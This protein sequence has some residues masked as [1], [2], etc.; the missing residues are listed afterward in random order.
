MSSPVIQQTNEVAGIFAEAAKALNDR[1]RTVIAEHAHKGLLKSGATVRRFG[2]AFEAEARA[3]AA[4]AAILGEGQRSPIMRTKLAEAIEAGV[5]SL[6]DV[7]EAKLARLGLSDKAAH[8][9]LQER[10]LAMARPATRPMA[11]RGWQVPGWA[12]GIGLASAKGAFRWI[13]GVAA[14]VLAGY[15]I[16]RM[17]W[18]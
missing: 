9:H 1:M 17:G 13:A 14:A 6:E 15:I 11:G 4:E 12:K 5:Q 3:A 10:R 18:L 2:E 7:T 16:Y 8:D